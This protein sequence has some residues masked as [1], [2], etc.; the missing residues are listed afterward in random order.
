MLPEAERAVVAPEKILRYLLDPTNP[1][2]QGKHGVFFALGYTR[3]TWERLRDDLLTHGHMHPVAE[4][5]LQGHA[6]VYNVDGVL[7]GP[8]GRTR[9]IR[10]AWRIDRAGVPPRLITAFPAPSGRQRP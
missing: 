5:E 3:E 10:T 9:Q 6:T 8:S 4:V 1:R 2:N 7:T